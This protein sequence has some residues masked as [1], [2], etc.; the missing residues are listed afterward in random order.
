MGRK[1][2]FRIFQTANKG[3]L[4]QKDL[5]RAKKEKSQERN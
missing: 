4:T 1:T 2:T 5:D 3:N